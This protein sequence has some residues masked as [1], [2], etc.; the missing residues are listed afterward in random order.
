[1]HRHSLL[2]FQAE[3]SN[4]A[5]YFPEAGEL[6]R[7]CSQT[8]SGNGCNCVFSRREIMAALRRRYLKPKK[9]LRTLRGLIARFRSV[10]FSL[11][12]IVPICMCDWPREPAI[13]VY[14]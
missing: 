12:E 3:R 4:G 5:R 10:T 13:L 11:L 9:S 8:L 14:V 6:V 1:M 2:R 7:P